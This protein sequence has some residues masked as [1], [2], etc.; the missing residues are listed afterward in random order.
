MTPVGVAW[1]QG[2]LEAL[3][4]I[5]SFFYDLIPSYGVAIILLTL[6]VRV[7]LLPLAIKQ[8]H[9]MRQLQAIQPKVRA[10]QQKYKGNRQ[11]LNEEL[12]KLYQEHGYNP[13]SG[14]L[15]LLAQIPVFIA[16]YSVLRGDPTKAT[17]MFDGMNN[18]NP[19]IA[20]LPTGSQLARDIQEGRANFLG[21]NLSCAP[22]QAGR[23]LVDLVPGEGE[24]RVNC[25][26][27]VVAQIPFYTLIL[28]MV[29]STWYQQRQM[30]SAAT[31]P[32][33]AQMRMMT[34]IMPI[35]LGVISW[36]IPAGVLVYWVTT[37]GWQI[38]QQRLMLGS[39]PQPAVEAGPARGRPSNGGKGKPASGKAGRGGS[40]DARGRKKRPKR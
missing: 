4:Q 38:V 8:I 21:M 39:Q 36:S 30:Q 29:G 22:Q 1:W 13:L 12:M 3:G 24:A 16:L 40:G 14:C 23:G 5:L 11:K 28:L 31:G 33:A 32:Q 2:L 27:G 34:R 7:I 6:L 15:P 10:V 35:F 17:E 25:G 19:A 20:H 18:V 9:S 37:N 26:T